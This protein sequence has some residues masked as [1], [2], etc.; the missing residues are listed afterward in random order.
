MRGDW[1]VGRPSTEEQ[2]SVSGYEFKSQC[3][4]ILH[5]DFET[6]CIPVLHREHDT[7]IRSFRV[8]NS[9]VNGFRFAIKVCIHWNHVIMIRRH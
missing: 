2:G 1:G 9:R 6:I 8:W 7:F 5:L 3:V 4:Y